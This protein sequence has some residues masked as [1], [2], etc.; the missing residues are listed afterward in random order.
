MQ[1]W[2]EQTLHDSKLD[3]P[4][5]SCIPVS[6]HNASYCYALAVSSLCNESEPITCEEAQSLDSW[7]VAMQS[8]YDAIVTCLMARR[9]LAQSGYARGT[10]PAE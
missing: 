1:K 7:M 4:L 5:S 9:L 6:L 3:V 2:L 8:K 10:H